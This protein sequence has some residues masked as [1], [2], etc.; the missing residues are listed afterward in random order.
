MNKEQPVAVT[1]VEEQ[2]DQDIIETETYSMEE[3]QDEN[4]DQYLDITPY[5]MEQLSMIME[6]HQAPYERRPLADLDQV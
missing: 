2:E 4:T 6:C 1:H 5:E 3:E